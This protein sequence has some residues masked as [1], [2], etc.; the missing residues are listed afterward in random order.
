MLSLSLLV[1]A[2]SALAIV[3]PSAIIDER[4]LPQVTCNRGSTTPL[5]AYIGGLG[6]AVALDVTG[7]D[8]S[9]KIGLSP[10]GDVPKFAFESCQDIEGVDYSQ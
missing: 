6:R 4:S 7:G 3:P 5:S 9:A 8:S 2:T 10:S 1:L